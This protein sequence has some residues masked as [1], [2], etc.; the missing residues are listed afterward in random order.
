MEN[1][2]NKYMI[3]KIQY[4]TTISTYVLKYLTCPIKDFVKSVYFNF[5]GMLSKY[6]THLLKVS[7]DVFPAAIETSN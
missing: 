3:V 5:S 1:K 4:I 2:F 6:C 7:L